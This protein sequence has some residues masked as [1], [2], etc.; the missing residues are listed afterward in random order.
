MSIALSNG[1]GQF[2]KWPSR[3]RDMNPA[4]KKVKIKIK[5]GPPTT[6][7]EFSDEFKRLLK[8]L[9]EKRERKDC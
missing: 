7:F 3:F 6:K 2:Y 1:D 5:T 9:E 8:K 4:R